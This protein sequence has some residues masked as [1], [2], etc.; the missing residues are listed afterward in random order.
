[1][2]RVDADDVARRSASSRRTLR[3]VEGGVAGPAAGAN[4]GPTGGLGEMSFG[5]ASRQSLALGPG[6]HSASL[7][8]P[9]KAAD[10][11][12]A[13]SLHSPFPAAC[14]AAKRGGRG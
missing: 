2:M 6:S 3:D 12:G 11:I 9:G 1:M 13:W 4:L 10:G 8:A 5:A 14:N 7:H